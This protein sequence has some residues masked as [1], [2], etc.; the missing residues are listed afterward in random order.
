PSTATSSISPSEDPATQVRDSRQEP[1]GSELPAFDSVRNQ[2]QR[3]PDQGKARLFAI[4]LRE[5]PDL[6]K[7]EFS[8]L[9]SL[10]ATRTTTGLPCERIYFASGKGICLSRET[11]YFSAQTVATLFDADFR[12]LSTVRTDGIP[13]RARISP[14]GRYAAF[15]TFVT[16][17]S[18]SDAQLS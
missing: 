1:V 18:Y 5:S 15:T 9:D 8:F 10:D 4:N 6:G 11:Q 7:V 14:D 2:S 16:G 13:S 17:H 3:Q 12:P